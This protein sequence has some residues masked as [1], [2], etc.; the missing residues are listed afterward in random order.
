VLEAGV[1]LLTLRVGLQELLWTEPIIRAGN[2]TQCLLA[3]ADLSRPLN[4]G[5]LALVTY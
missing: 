3:E 4:I 1:V 5:L 2:F